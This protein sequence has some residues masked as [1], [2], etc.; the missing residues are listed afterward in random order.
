MTS[1]ESYILP[2]VTSSQDF[3][4]LHGRQAMLPRGVE[5]V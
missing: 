4:C 2:F 5:P 3:N 1:S